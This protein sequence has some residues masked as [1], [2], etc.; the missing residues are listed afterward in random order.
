MPTTNPTLNLSLN[1]RNRRR[2]KITLVMIHLN[3]TKLR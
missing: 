2:M 1:S 3:W